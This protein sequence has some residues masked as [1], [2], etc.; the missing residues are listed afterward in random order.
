MPVAWKL[1]LPSLV[2]IPAAAAG[3]RN[4]SFNAGSTLR[5]V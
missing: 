3:T 1:W 5:I 4:S 2:T